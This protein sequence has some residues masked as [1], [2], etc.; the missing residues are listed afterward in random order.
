MRLRSLY[1]HANRS[2]TRCRVSLTGGGGWRRFSATYDCMSR[3]LVAVILARLLCLSR[4]ESRFCSADLFHGRLDLFGTHREQPLA[5]APNRVQRRK[6][7][8]GFFAEAFRPLRMTMV[9]APFYGCRARSN[10]AAHHVAP[11]R[12][13]RRVAVATETV[14]PR[15]LFSSK[16]RNPGC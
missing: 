1:K 7:S 6:R 11:P 16:S 5:Q 14:L 15:S 13:S 2:P 9:K 10:S 8:P 4:E 3:S 12:A